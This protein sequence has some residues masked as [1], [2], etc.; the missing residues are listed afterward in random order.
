MSEGDGI[1]RKAMRTRFETI[2]ADQL[3]LRRQITE[4]AAAYSDDL[5]EQRDY[6]RTLTILLISD[7]VNPLRDKMI[8]CAQKPARSMLS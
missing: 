6:R 5:T 2:R 8:G 1:D 7:A 3:R 4:M